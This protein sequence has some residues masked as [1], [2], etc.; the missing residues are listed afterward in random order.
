MVFESARSCK[1]MI[2]NSLQHTIFFISYVGLHIT[3]WN[4]D[5]ESTGG[6]VC[7]HSIYIRL[8]PGIL[9]MFI[10]WNIKTWPKCVYWWH[11]INVC[12]KLERNFFFHRWTWKYNW[13]FY[14]NDNSSY[15]RTF[16]VYLASNMMRCVSYLPQVGC[17]L[18]ALRLPPSAA[19]WLK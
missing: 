17:S 12:L 6:L 19:I 9:N 13:Q 7:F 1:N 2:Y 5:R 8:R 16:Y 14:Y 15:A 10:V 18:W 11:L 3:G 4:M